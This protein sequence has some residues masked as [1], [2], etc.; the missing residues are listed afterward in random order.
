MSRFEL[1]GFSRDV[2]TFGQW[3]LHWWLTIITFIVPQFVLSTLYQ[4]SRSSAKYGLTTTAY[5]A[6]IAFCYLFVIFSSTCFQSRQP[7]QNLKIAQGL[8]SMDLETQNLQQITFCNLKCSISFN[9]LI[10]KVWKYY[11]S[12]WGASEHPSKQPCHQR[13]NCYHVRD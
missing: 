8:P 12:E 13:Q 6:T 3:T 1:I 11:Y 10:A 5:Q 7:C 4:H 9:D 2:L